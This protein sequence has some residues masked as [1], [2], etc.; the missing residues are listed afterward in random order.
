MFTTTLSTAKLLSAWKS[1]KNEIVLGNR[2]INAWRGIQVANT[3]IKERQGLWDT[4]A[5][6]LK[7]QECNPNNPLR[8]AQDHRSLPLGAPDAPY[9]PKERAFLRLQLVFRG[10][11]KTAP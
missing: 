9:T 6:A 7:K 3:T 1:M 10:F 8:C 2:L 5:N 11:G 4:Y